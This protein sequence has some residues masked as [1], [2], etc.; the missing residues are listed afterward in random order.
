MPC[1]YKCCNGSELKEVLVAGAVAKGSVEYDLKL[2]HHKRGHHCLRLLQLKERD[3]LGGKTSRF[4]KTS[5]SQGI[6]A[7]THTALEDDDSLN[8]LSYNQLVQSGRGYSR[9]L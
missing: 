5:L 6:C 1:I 3:N 2:K 9:T 4:R 7:A 8:S